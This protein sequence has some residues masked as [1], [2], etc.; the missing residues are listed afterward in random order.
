MAC[1]A[2]RE[3]GRANMRGPPLPPLPA[4]PA[5]P[6]AGQ[7][8]CSVGAT[9]SPHVPCL[10]AVAVLRAAFVGADLQHAVGLR[11]GGGT[12]GRMCMCVHGGRGVGGGGGGLPAPVGALR[13]LHAWRDWACTAPPN[14]PGAQL[15]HK[16]HVGQAG[17]QL[18]HQLQGDR[19]CWRQRQLAAARA[20]A[21]A[22]VGGV[23][24]GRQRGVGRR[25]QAPAAA[26]RG[27]GGPPRTQSCRSRQRP[28]C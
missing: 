1:S 19:P 22:R 9:P 24:G 10:Q 17:L 18:N 21:C 27:P 13:P 3:A 23:E 7:H 15:A 20:R 8:R 11:T 5:A 6:G 16:C 25:R 14:S 28:P 4:A 26:V 12:R 2:H